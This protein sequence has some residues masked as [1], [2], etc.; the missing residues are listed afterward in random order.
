MLGTISLYPTYQ[1]EAFQNILAH[2]IQ[3][4]V[5]DYLLNVLLQTGFLLSL[6]N[7]LQF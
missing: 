7:F 4:Y 5:Y 6:H 1:Y 3:V 2:Q